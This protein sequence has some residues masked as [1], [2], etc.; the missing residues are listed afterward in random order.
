M[1]FCSNQEDIYGKFACKYD[2][3]TKTGTYLSLKLNFVIFV[4]FR[5]KIE[6]FY[7]YSI[8]KIN[9]FNT[10]VKCFYGIS[11]MH[12]MFSSQST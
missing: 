9:Q 5:E 1:K 3:L 6:N 7:D 12:G 10:S 2:I 11:I 4:N 8:R